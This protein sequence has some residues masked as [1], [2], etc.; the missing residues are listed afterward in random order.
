MSAYPPHGKGAYIL[1]CD[2]PKLCNNEKAFY[3]EADPFGF[4]LFARNIDNKDQICALTDD[5]RS[6][7]GWNAPI[8]ID[9]EGGRVQRLHAPLVREWPAPLDHVRQ[10]GDRAQAVIHA[11][12]AVIAQELKQLGITAN[13]IPTADIA[14]KQTHPVLKNRCFGQNAKIVSQMAEAAAKGL[15]EGGVLPVMKHMPG[16][17]LA[18]IDSH[19]AAPHTDASLEMLEN[20]D[21]KPFRALNQLLMGMTAHVVYEAIDPERP[22]TISPAVHKLIRKSIGF[23]GLLISDDLS[24]KALG[25]NAESRANAVITA[26]CDVV[27]HCNGQLDEM[28][29]VVEAAGQMGSKARERAARV[30]R[31][32]CALSQ[33]EVDISQLTAQLDTM[34]QN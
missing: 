5:L 33:R 21:F 18:E 8:F 9:Q 2:G 3:K 12:Y 26:G 28:H 17:G 4:I 10:A 11:R 32:H 30:I 27:L 13:C 24:M 25:G 7:V 31:M 34:S 16:H 29:A 19:L 1:G 20:V 23:D 22:G 14:R 6:A 15:L